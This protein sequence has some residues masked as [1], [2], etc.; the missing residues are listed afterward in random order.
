VARFLFGY[1]LPPD[2]LDVHFAAPFPKNFAVD[3]MRPGDIY[4][5]G[6]E[7]VE[8]L[9]EFTLIDAPVPLWGPLGLAGNRC[10]PRHPRHV[11]VVPVEACHGLRVPGSSRF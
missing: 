11:Y 5:I 8:K 9:K 2:F 1:R 6:P 7:T 3:D 4:L 10:F